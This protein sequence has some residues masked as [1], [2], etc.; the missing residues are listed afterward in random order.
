MTTR[1][2]WIDLATRESDGLEVSLLWNKS[3]DRVKVTVADSKLDEQFEL[4]VDGPHALDAFHHP[5]AYACGRGVCFTGA[6]RESL[7]LQLQN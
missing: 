7:D 1:D 3:T 2:I 4:D 6:M 5:F